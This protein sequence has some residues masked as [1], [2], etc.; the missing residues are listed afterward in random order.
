MELERLGLLTLRP[1]GIEGPRGQFLAGNLDRENQLIFRPHGSQGSGDDVAGKVGSENQMTSGQLRKNQLTDRQKSYNPLKTGTRDKYQLLSGSCEEQQLTVV[2]KSDNTA[3]MAGLPGGNQLIHRPRG[4]DKQFSDDE[5]KNRLKNPS[6]AGF[7]CDNLLTLERFN[8]VCQ[9]SD[10]QLRNMLDNNEAS[11]KILKSNNYL[12]A[13]SSDKKSQPI[14]D[15]EQL[16]NQPR[17]Y[18]NQLIAQSRGETNQRMKSTSDKSQLTDPSLPPP[19]PP[20][21]PVRKLPPQFTQSHATS[22]HL[23]RRLAQP[24]PPPE[25]AP[26]SGQASS[27]SSAGMSPWRNAEQQQRQLPPRGPDLSGSYGFLGGSTPYTTTWAPAEDDGGPP[28]LASNSGM[29]MRRS[30]VRAEQQGGGIGNS[31]RWRADAMTTKTAATLADGAAVAAFPFLSPDDIREQLV[32]KVAA[33]SDRKNILQQLSVH[34]VF[35]N[36]SKFLC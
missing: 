28:Q 25:A 3:L 26:V 5:V 24:K 13:A 16:T 7:N 32:N 18:K 11:F 4:E 9:F 22:E 27:V 30:A 33:S 21:P 8:V 1:R 19:P 23:D 35:L 20:P 29:M 31:N 12:V 36:N 2:S 10:Q 14:R 34:I 6:A 15:D 17:D